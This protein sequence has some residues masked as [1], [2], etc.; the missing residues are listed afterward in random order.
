[1]TLMELARQQGKAKVAIAARVG[2]V[3]RDLA[4]PVPPEGNVEWVTIQDTAGIEIMRHSTAHVMAAAVKELFPDAR[5]TI[6]PAIENGFYYDFDVEKPFT[7]EDIDRIEEKMGEIVRA[8]Y[9][10]LREEMTKQEARERFP[11]EPY[12]GEMLDEIPESTVS[13]Y[14]LGNF[15]DLCRGPHLPS[16]GKVGAY[17]LMNTAGA[18]WRGDSRNRMLT[19]IYG[20]AFAKKKELEEHLRLLEEVKKRDHRRLGKE[21]DLFSTNEEI[22]PG[23]ILW[24]PKGSVVRRIMEDFWREEHAR[25]GYDLVFSPHIARID[26]WR[27]SGHL[28]FYRQSMFAS[29]GVEGQDYQLKPMD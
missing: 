1:M 27:M 29:I 26:L 8:D 6:G 7:P 28:D 24:H 2:G 13:L 12:K 23:L 17:K 4:A 18:Y 11:G 10:F 25:A 16:S 20:C 19:R 15:L 22:G 14:R 5:I 9:P 21:L 3:L